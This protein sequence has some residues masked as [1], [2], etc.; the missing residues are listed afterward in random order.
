LASAKGLVLF[1][2]YF[3]TYFP[4]CQIGKVG[5]L[6]N[7]AANLRLPPKPR[8]VDGKWPYCKIDGILGKIGF[9]RIHFGLIH[10]HSAK[11]TKCQIPQ[12]LLKTSAKP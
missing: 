1:Q 12:L 3:S 2:V 5:K 6:A 4:F 10:F 11:Q 8:E 9:K 7:F